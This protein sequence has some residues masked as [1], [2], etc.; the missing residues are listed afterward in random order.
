MIRAVLFDFAHTLVDC[1]AWFDLEIRTLVRDTFAE[2]GRRGALHLDDERLGRAEAAFVRVRREAKEAETEAEAVVSLR[3][4]LTEIGIDGLPGGVLDGAVAA[5]QR[6]CLASV[7]ARPGA[8]V[9]IT[10]LRARGIRLG[11]VSN[12]AY[13]PFVD[14]ALERCGLAADFEVV[15]TSAAA[16]WRKPRPEIFWRALTGLGV[17]PSEAAYVGD[18]HPY[19]V[20]GARAAGLRSIWLP[21]VRS[22]VA[23]LTADA[24]IADLRE[25]PNVIQRWN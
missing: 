14:W 20:V 18:Y 8:A 4:V 23:G 25:V 19:D 6:G 9:A 2:L 15:L 7:A 11:V 5:V 10:A 17:R 24:I 3:R 22:P 12:A 21:S 16:G 1:D 13:A